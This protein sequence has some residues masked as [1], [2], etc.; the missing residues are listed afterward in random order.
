MA[1]AIRKSA[2]T[3]RKK[4]KRRKP[5]PKKKE[6]LKTKPKK[7]TPKRARPKKSKQTASLSAYYLGLDIGVSEEEAADLYIAKY[8]TEPREIIMTGGATLVGPLPLS[9]VAALG[10]GIAHA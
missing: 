10:S 6:I 2:P 1:K 5:Q 9:I 8:N 4:P 3:Q 7:A